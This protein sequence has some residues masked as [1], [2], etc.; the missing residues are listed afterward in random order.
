MSFLPIPAIED[1]LRDYGAP[2]V[3]VA[4]MLESMGAPLPGESL[5]IAAAIYAATT[6]KISIWALLPFAAGGAILGDQIGYLLGRW[7]G[8]SVLAR[9]GRRIGISDERLQLGRY[10]FRR[11][12]G[13][14][15]F[16][17]RFV[18]FL[19][20][21]AAVLAGANRMPWG[22]F[23]LWNGLGGMVWTVG[24]GLGAYLAGDVFK[25]LHGPLA[26]GLGVAG[27]VMLAVVV[28]FV[29]KH[30][31]RL[32]E[33]ARQQMGGIEAVPVRVRVRSGA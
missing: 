9:W 24:Y 29:K 33:D 25:R 5:L 13:G 31:S 18:A 1:L 7:I 23:L 12:G 30:E 26:V 22:R 17:G 21:V 2:G 16:L 4:L 11:Y 19:R 8:F 20:T 27:A 10:L 32:L 28:W 14:V 3:G 15:V 6:G